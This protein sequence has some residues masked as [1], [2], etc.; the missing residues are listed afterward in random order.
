[1]FR[2]EEIDSVVLFT[3][4]IYRKSRSFCNFSA[5][6]TPWGWRKIKTNKKKKRIKWTKSLF[7]WT[8]YWVM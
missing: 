8:H 2:Q 5:L 1:M 3:V 6:Y 4:D 7:Q